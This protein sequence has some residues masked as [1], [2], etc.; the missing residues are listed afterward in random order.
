MKESKTTFAY[1]VEHMDEPSF[2]KVRNISCDFIQKL[3]SGLIDELFDQLNR[4]VELLDNEPLLQMYFY[5]YGQMHAEKLMYAFKQ[6]SPYIKSA[7]KIDIV[8]YGCGQGLATMCY[9]DFIKGY[10]LQQKVHSIT[11][12]EPSAVALSRAELLCNCFFP[13][14]TITAI[15]KGF[16]ELLEDDIRIDTDCPTLHLFSNILDVESYDITPLAN[17]IKSSCHGDNDFVIVSPMQNARRI[18]RLSEFVDFLGVDCYFRKCL[19][20]QQLREDKD[21]TCCAMLCSTRDREFANINVEE[22]H[23]KVKEFFGDITIWRDKES[24]KAIFNEVKICASNGDAECMNV[25]GLFY[26]KGILVEKSYKEAFTWFKFAAENGFPNAIRNLALMY[27]RGHGVERNISLAIETINRLKE[28]DTPLYY[29]TLGEIEKIAGNH[30]TAF[31]NFRIASELGNTRAKWLYGTYLLKGK[32]C[33]KNIILGVKN[34]RSAAKDSIT[35]ACL[36]MARYYET[37]FKEG[38]IDQSNNLS[39]KNYKLAAKN[40]SLEAQKRLAEIYKNGILGVSKNQKE[41]FKWY[42]IAAERGDYD[43]AFYVALF[44]A[45]GNGIEKNYVEA[46]KWYKI[47]A[48]HGSSSAMNNLAIC[49]EN[50]RGVEKDE[51]EAFSFYL[52]AAEAGGSVAANNVS[53]C[54]QQGTGTKVNPQQALFWK[55]KAA[56]NGNSKAQKKLSEW[57]FK[58]YGTSRN[59]EKALFWFVKSKLEKEENIVVGIGSLFNTIKQKANDGNAL[60]QYLLAKCYAYG[61]FVSKDVSL[62]MVWYEKSAANGFVEALIKLRRIA[63]I[64]TKATDEEKAAGEKDEYGVLYSKDGKKVLTC[65]FVHRKSYNIRKGTRIICD[66]AF[67][68]QSI[69]QLIIPSSVVV[70][71]DNPFASD[72]YYH[73]TKIAIKNQSPFFMVKED[74]LYSK[75]GSTIIAYWGKQKR[76]TIP[77]NVKYIANGCFSNSRNLEEI[78]MPEGIESIGHLAFEDCYSL[79]SLDLPKSVK[80]IGTAAFWG[81]EALEEIW[82]LGSIS[83]I[84][85]N[86]F[87]GCNLKYVHLPS[88]LVSIKDSAFNSNSELRHID[89][90][91][92]LET[93]G[94]YAFAYCSDLER[95]NLGNSVKLIGDLC[96]YGCAIQQVRIPSSLTN[97]GIRPFDKIKNIITGNNGHFKAERGML[98]NQ[99]TKNLECYFGDSSFISLEGIRSISPL[100]FYESDV[101]EVVLP[102]GVCSLSEYA[103]YNS[104]N[105]ANIKLSEGIEFLGIGSFWGCRNLRSISIPKSVYEIKSAAFGRCVSLER[106]E[107]KGLSTNTSESI[108]EYQDSDLFPSAYHSHCTTMG[109][110]IEE[111][112]LNYKPD[113]E[114]FKCITIVVPKST[115]NKYTFNPIHHCQWNQR[116]MDRRFNIIENDED[117]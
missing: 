67:G 74:A 55:E 10:N 2:E 41:S 63:S 116:E 108:F 33:D 65:S 87:E 21:W 37:G 4:G 93:I 45:N 43:A 24:A 75:D 57:Y 85:P 59:Y 14:A 11:L 107:F 5:S 99:I 39:V 77:N 48:D 84:E 78:Y 6:L 27:V 46:V 40:G 56:E 104:K 102:N 34:I 26:T 31:E 96:F 36:R 8:D 89:F 95:V 58:G 13:E 88:C 111:L 60:Y 20:K 82:S 83:T 109:S 103:F 79:K 72:P 7:E 117:C 32:Y 106:I 44:Y 53:I 91:D 69:E 38:G 94:N 98:I 115:K 12:I 49:Y 66:G 113:V 71:G 29:L 97:M 54:Y 18:S 61:V 110:F 15:Q 1:I 76:F 92:M 80:F 28:R 70:I 50:G 25:M 81:C 9:H 100:A 42:L 114:S 101:V 86:T 23:R 90:P 22:I 30:K 73:D 51:E 16:D 68:N 19:D 35:P 17:K 3:P 64:S 52:K 112:D 105:L 47:A 62:S